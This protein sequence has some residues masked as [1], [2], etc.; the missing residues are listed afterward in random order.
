MRSESLWC[1][2]PTWEPEPNEFAVHFKESVI[3]YLV[4]VVRSRFVSQGPW[5]LVLILLKHTLF[6]DAYCHGTLLVFWYAR[7]AL[8]FES[9]SPLWND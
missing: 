9:E 1:S 6:R 2:L 8:T 5:S 3:R 7:N 4:I